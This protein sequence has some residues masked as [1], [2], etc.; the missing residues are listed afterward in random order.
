MYNV[1][2]RLP[3]SHLVVSTTTFPNSEPSTYAQH[4]RHT[5]ASNL[6]VSAVLHPRQQPSINEF[7]RNKKSD[8]TYAVFYKQTPTVLWFKSV[9]IMQFS[10]KILSRFPCVS[11]RK[12]WWSADI[13]NYGLAYTVIMK[14]LK[15]SNYFCRDYHLCVNNV[16][17]TIALATTMFNPEMFITG[18]I[19]KDGKLLL[20]NF[21]I[22]HQVGETRYFR[23]L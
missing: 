3:S 8:S 9:D 16:F 4:F 10:G 11:R 21:G 14:F 22:G 17:T 18:S 7:S 20:Q 2:I 19:F 5:L 15:M 12:K 6:F 1:R 23:K 13:E